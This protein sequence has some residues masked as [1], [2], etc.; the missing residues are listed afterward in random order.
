MLSKH[1][2]Y[3]NNTVH[4]LYF[5]NNG[6]KK[7]ANGP[8]MKI[9][10]SPNGWH[11]CADIHREKSNVGMDIFK[12]NPDAQW[13]M[14]MGGFWVRPESKLYVWLALKGVEMGKIWSKDHTGPDWRD[15]D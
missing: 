7:L 6:L 11:F 8:V 2:K 14:N 15:H 1:K 9:H 13:D 12:N 10:S 3:M 4:P 5:V